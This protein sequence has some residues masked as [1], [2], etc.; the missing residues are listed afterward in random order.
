MLI[1]ILEMRVLRAVD[2]VVAAPAMDATSAFAGSSIGG[3]FNL[4][5]VASN[6]G[7]TGFSG[8]VHVDTV[9]SRDTIIGN[10]D[11][12]VDDTAFLNK[13]IAPGETIDT[14]SW[15]VQF[16][17]VPGPGG[18]FVALVVDSRSELTE[19]NETNNT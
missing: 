11:D 16:D 15:L 13:A 4:P 14:G 10:A 3:A 8:Q 17:T 6:P 19:A 12:V 7:T 5:I 1:G 18:Y 9:L 2:F